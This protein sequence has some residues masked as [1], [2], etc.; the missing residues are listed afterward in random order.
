M[1]CHG[2][3][4]SYITDYED[5][6][7]VQTAKRIGADCIVARKQIDYAKLLRAGSCG[8]IPNFV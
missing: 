6:V 1:D 8:S 3:I 4:A 5:A 7:M 2:A